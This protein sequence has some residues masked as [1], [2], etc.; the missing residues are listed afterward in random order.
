MEKIEQPLVSIVMVNYNHEEYIG[1]SIESVLAQTYEKWE[2]IIIDDGSTDESVNIISSYA[3]KDDRIKFYPQKE[4]SQICIVT[5]IGFSYVKGELVARLDSDDIWK[6]EKL[7]KQLQYMAENPEGALCFTKLDII[8]E[9]GVIIND[10]MPELYRA[11]NSRRENRQGWLRQFF[12]QGNTLIQST[13]L[14][15]KEVI[16][17]IGIFNLAYMQGHDFDFFVRS[18]LKYD[19]IFLEEPLTEYR[20]TARQNSALNPDNNRRFFN[21]FMN[22][23][24]HYFDNMPDELFK[25]VFQEYFLNKE[26]SSHE[27][28]LCEQAFLLCRCTDEDDPNPVLGLAKLEEL[29]EN[30]RIVELLKEKFHYTP[31][32][33]YEQSR[34]HLFYSQEIVAEKGE[35][36]WKN[37]QLEIEIDSLKKWQKQAHEKEQQKEEQLRQM[38]QEMQLKEQQIQI[39]REK[40]N[41]M[42]NSTSWKIT[43]PLR[44]VGKRMK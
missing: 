5:N 14:M 9:N 15:K 33:Y 42:E 1:K 11:Y 19:F 39:L 20:R 23:R 4:N 27:E 32:D 25:E 13:L 2:L 17:E 34:K 43:K 30:P 24:F 16:D 44:E 36:M 18:A 6:P 26:S 7:E 12:F 31:K 41:Q 21:E 8:N 40:V 28:L 10:E 35:L 29:M 37:N 22:V 3:A 38:N